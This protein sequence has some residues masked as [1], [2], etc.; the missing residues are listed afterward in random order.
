[1]EVQL[2]HLH[3][4][5]CTVQTL[6]FFQLTHS[7]GRDAADPQHR[8]QPTNLAIRPVLCYVQVYVTHNIRL[9]GAELWQL[10]TQQGAVVCVSGSAQKMPSDVAAAFED[11]AQQHGG[12]SREQAAQYVRQMELQG[13]YLVEAWS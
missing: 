2:Y 13:R 10:I 7:P 1:M 5:A 6:S 3:S 8:S 11:V 12:M 4:T 9:Y